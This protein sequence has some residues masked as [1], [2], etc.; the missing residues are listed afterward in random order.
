MLLEQEMGETPSKSRYRVVVLGA[1]NATISLPLIAHSLR[2]SLPYA[3]IFT[4]VGH[5]RSYGIWSN[6]LY[7][8]LP[9]ITECN[10]WD[11]LEEDNE[12][13]TTVALITDIGNDLLYGVSTEQ[14]LAWVADCV[15][16]LKKQNSQTVITLLPFDSLRNL[17]RARFMATRTL[18][19]PRSEFG[20]DGFLDRVAAINETLTSW[21]DESVRVV[22]A[23]SEWYGFD[24]IHIRPKQRVNAWG[25]ILSNWHL[26]E[27]KIQMVRPGWGARRSIRRCQFARRRF[28]GR[29]QSFAQPM[30]EWSGTDR[31]GKLCLF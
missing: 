16:R 15:E 12:P 25:E 17:S 24:P 3:D 23:R 11:E 27:E 26:G 21:S 19:F 28:L 6:V 4:A 1:S 14:T 18:F 13:S 7:R 29:E 30:L 22:E 20:Y 2:S 8:S 9:G 10:L 31:R 5:G